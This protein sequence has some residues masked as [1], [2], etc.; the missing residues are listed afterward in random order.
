MK[1]KD[2]RW[3]SVLKSKRDKKKLEKEIRYMSDAEIEI[4]G[5]TLANNYF[6]LSTDTIPTNSAG[7]EQYLDAHTQDYEQAREVLVSAIKS[8]GI[9]LGGDKRLFLSKKD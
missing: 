3:Q 6:G 1:A 9:E 2:I 5:I 8:S 4:L 7:L